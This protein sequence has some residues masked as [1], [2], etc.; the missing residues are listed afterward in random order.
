MFVF[1]LQKIQ[2]TVAKAESI[3]FEVEE[4]ERPESAD[5]NKYAPEDMKIGQSN[6]KIETDGLTVVVRKDRQPVVK[7]DRFISSFTVG[8]NSSLKI[9]MT[10]IVDL[11]GKSYTVFY[12]GVIK[13]K[14]L[15]YIS[16]REALLMRAQIF[17]FIQ[18]ILEMESVPITRIYFPFF[19]F[20]TNKLQ[21]AHDVPEDVSEE[22]AE[23]E[24]SRP[25]TDESTDEKRPESRETANGTGDDAQGDE[26]GHGKRKKHKHKEKKN[27]KHKKKDKK[28]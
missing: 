27:K 6:Q 13:L 20:C 8:L 28:K 16:K 24:D 4:N 1:Q 10:F 11:S 22:G 19:V 7:D 9:V 25:A 12:F 2:A 3:E 5:G 17:K 18:V 15:I 14:I 26:A 23:N 21:E